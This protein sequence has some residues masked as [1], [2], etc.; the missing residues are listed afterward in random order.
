MPVLIDRAGKAIYEK[1]GGVV[2]HVTSSV[3]VHA[4]LKAGFKVWPVTEAQF[5]KLAATSKGITGIDP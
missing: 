4:A 5:A 2:T 3:D 1:D